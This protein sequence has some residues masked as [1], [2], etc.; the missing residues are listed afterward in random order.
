MG[1]LGWVWDPA[2]CQPVP[3]KHTASCW[4]QYA[5]PSN[6]S[7]PSDPG[8]RR[9]LWAHSQERASKGHGRETWEQGE[10][11]WGRQGGAG[12]LKMTVQCP[13]E[14]WGWAGSSQVNLHQV[15]QAALTL[16]V[17]EILALGEAGAAEFRAGH[18]LALGH[19]HSLAIQLQHH[20]L[21]WVCRAQ[22]GPWVTQ[23]S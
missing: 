6:D 14:P 13:A 18:G 7:S 15:A 12:R 20:V 8:F 2:C 17:D 9:G 10:V 19:C 21:G 5:R 22:Q 11:I 23:G 16:Q 1:S 4:L 3:L